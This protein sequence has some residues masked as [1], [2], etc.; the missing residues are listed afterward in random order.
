MIKVTPLKGHLT[1]C[2]LGTP[3]GGVFVELAGSLFR[4]DPCGISRRCQ[5][6]SNSERDLVHQVGEV[7][8]D[9]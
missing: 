2:E 5:P 1:Q 9:I 3:K 6:D 4:F 8:N 7:V